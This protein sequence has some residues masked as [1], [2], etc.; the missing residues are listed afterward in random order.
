MSSIRND[1]TRKQ[2]SA[3][4]KRDNHPA[5]GRLRATRSEPGA[6]EAG[7]RR[8]TPREGWRLLSTSVPHL[9][10]APWGV[11]LAMATLEKLALVV[12]AGLLAAG[13]LLAAVLGAT[14]SFP[15]A[16]LRWLLSLL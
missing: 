15:L 6:G 10:D 7:A 3:V 16:L 5:R 12:A 8:D 11:R 13:L 14:P 2:A 1:V 4:R 9:L